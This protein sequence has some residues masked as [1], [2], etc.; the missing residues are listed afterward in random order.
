VSDSWEAFCGVLA[1]ESAA[2]LRVH[3]LAMQL[4][5]ALVRSS[6]AEIVT[7]GRAVDEA[8]R[9]YQAS[10]A[11]RRAM[12]ARGFGRMS[13]RHVCGYAPRR[14]RQLLEQRVYE[15]TTLAV[16]LKI[17]A[18]NNKALIVAGMD[19]L[20]QITTSLQRAASREPKTYKRR[21]FVPPPTNSVLVVK[22]A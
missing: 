17:T 10:S 7:A 5:R 16:G 6:P 3:D 4:T 8:R 11:K 14:Y 9:A 22:S 18:K 1:E 20:V 15:L 2:L 21:G 19:R 12:Q 13:L